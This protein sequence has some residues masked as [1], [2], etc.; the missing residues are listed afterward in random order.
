MPMPQ[1][2][3]ATSE[4]VTSAAGVLTANAF[5]DGVLSRD[6]D[7]AASLLTKTVSSEESTQ[8]VF[9]ALL[10]LSIRF[11][12]DSRTDPFTVAVKLVADSEQLLI[13]AKQYVEQV[14]QSAVL[15]LL[16]SDTQNFFKRLGR[17]LQR[18][19]N[20][21]EQLNRQFR[22]KIDSLKSAA[23][24]DS[25]IH[26]KISALDLEQI[27]RDIHDR[28]SDKVCDQHV[29]RILDLYG[30]RNDGEYLE[31]RRNL[32]KSRW[33][34]STVPEEVRGLV[35]FRRTASDADLHAEH[36]VGQLSKAVNAINDQLVLERQAVIVAPILDELADGLEGI[37][38]I[39]DLLRP[40][41][42]NS[43]LVQQLIKLGQESLLYSQEAATSNLCV[44][45]L[46]LLE[47]DLAQI[48]SE[49]Q[50]S[51]Q[52]IETEREQVSKL[53]LVDSLLAAPVDCLNKIN[54]IFQCSEKVA[55]MRDI[56][57]FGQEQD[58]NEL[59]EALQKTA[60][61]PRSES[62]F[63]FQRVELEALESSSRRSVEE[64]FDNCIAM[65]PRILVISSLIGDR[66]VS[67]TL[68]NLALK[69]NLP[70]WV[71]NWV[72][73]REKELGGFLRVGMQELSKEMVAYG[74]M[75]GCKQPLPPCL[76]FKAASLR[77]CCVDRNLSYFV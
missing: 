29:E 43:I 31:D 56:A 8:Q 21:L 58:K 39:I 52:V 14:E 48:F 15:R 45:K 1:L 12:K 30:H 25:Q 68:Q 28:L 59:I 57:I 75:H 72:N 17:H 16:L 5:Q 37:H 53:Q 60:L 70:S 55:L 54:Q 3:V 35:K 38:K 4:P 10:P 47:T 62:L 76:T 73:F 61:P 11:K 69:L 63:E 67:T 44:Q 27:N 65:L 26:S 23:N 22:E 18:N 19:E 6:S 50:K 32:R 41:F 51:L 74:R 36:V 13:I 71:S 20:E 24:L 64:A 9:Q 49:R 42:E 46:E 66:E 40:E 33:A 7:L 77:R 2:S 34:V